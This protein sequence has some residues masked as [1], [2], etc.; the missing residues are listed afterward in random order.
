MIEISVIK[1][2][3][4][5]LLDNVFDQGILI[6]GH[7]Q[8]EYSNG[9]MSGINITAKRVLKYLENIEDKNK[10]VLC[11]KEGEDIDK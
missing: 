11:I 8:S 1:K 3:L 5:K 9:Y 2:E 10:R 4:I 6:T 7:E